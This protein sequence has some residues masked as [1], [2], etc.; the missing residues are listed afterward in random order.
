MNFVLRITLGWRRANKVATWA[1]VSTPFAWRC[2][3]GLVRAAARRWL[4][5]PFGRAALDVFPVSRA[6]RRG[7]KTEAPTGTTIVH[8][9]WSSRSSHISLENVSRASPHVRTCAREVGAGVCRRWCL[10]PRT[11][12]RSL[13]GPPAFVQERRPPAEA[14]K[15]ATVEKNRP[16]SWQRWFLDGAGWMKDRGL[17][18]GDD[19]RHRR[20][21][22]T[23]RSGPCGR[24]AKADCR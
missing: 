6:N 22:D 4:T 1:V 17:V 18:E 13:K 19:V 20:S 10:D 11:R 3:A 24:S 8:R 23:P 2:T 12:H 16:L 9:A 15:L 7:P 21:T 14:G 5:A